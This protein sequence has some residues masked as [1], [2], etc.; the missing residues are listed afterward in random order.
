MKT[1]DY[2]DLTDMGQ[3]RNPGNLQAARLPL[4]NYFGAYEATIFSKPRIV[5]ERIS[6]RI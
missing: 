6:Y 4:Q 2:A 3:T 5:V 1:T